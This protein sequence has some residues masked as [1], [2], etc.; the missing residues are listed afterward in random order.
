MLKRAGYVGAMPLVAYALLIV[1]IGV[2]ASLRTCKRITPQNDLLR[3][4]EGLE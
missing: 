2:F 4:A 1:F 3:L